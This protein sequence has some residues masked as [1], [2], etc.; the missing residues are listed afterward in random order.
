MCHQQGHASSYQ[1]FAN[2]GCTIQL[3]LMVVVVLY[4]HN[5]E[6]ITNKPNA[7][8]NAIRLLQLKWLRQTTG[9]SGL[10]KT[11]RADGSDD[12]PERKWPVG[13]AAG[14]LELTGRRVRRRA[15]GVDKGARPPNGRAKK[16]LTLC[17]HLKDDI[18]V[19][20]ILKISKITRNYLHFFY[21]IS[22]K[23]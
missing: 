21:K 14:Q 8:F 19:T 1:M 18:S 4:L 3:S 5:Y 6:W 12:G 23:S 16:E 22:K 17:L 10:T 2:A 9:T 13:V 7:S 15:T 20:D 11:W